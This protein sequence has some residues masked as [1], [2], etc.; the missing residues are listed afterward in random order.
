MQLTRAFARRRHKSRQTP[1]V[2]VGALAVAYTVVLFAGFFAPYEFEKQ[3][4]QFALAPP[5]PI[6]FLDSKGQFHARPF[7]YGLVLR[8]GTFNEFEQSRSQPHFIRFFVSGTQYTVLGS[9]T[10]R[11]HLFG[12]DQETP[13]FLIGSDEYGRDQFSRLLYGGRISLFAGVL[14]AAIAVG[15]GMLLGGFA[16]YYGHI[17]DD[18]IMRATEVFLTV[19]WL[20]LL[21]IVR[22]ALP[23]R[24][25]PEKTFFLLITILGVIG[26]ARPARLIRG[27]V[28]VAKSQ[29]YVLAARCFGAS[30]AYL[31]RTHVLPQISSVAV[32]QALLFIPQYILAE[33][34]LSFFGL[35]ISEPVPSWGNMLAGLQ[36]YFVLR[37]CWWMC[38]PA[39]ALVM[40]LFAYYRILLFPRDRKWNGD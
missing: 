28:L 26:W 33:V 37:S 13:I 8:A 18:V 27:V 19:P 22:A 21:L 14:A 31:L 20:Y 11:W 9:F 17:V 40:V 5:T 15:F 12:T 6:H 16:G 3:N 23:L 1:V 29:E 2:A 4:R 35:G 24:T 38:A 34:T 7:I 10:S 36:S 32:T 39:I 25:G 30:D